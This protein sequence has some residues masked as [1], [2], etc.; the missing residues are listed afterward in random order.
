FQNR[1]PVPGSHFGVRPPGVLQWRF[2]RLSDGRL[3]ARRDALRQ[4]QPLLPG[5]LPGSPDTLQGS[6][7]ASIATGQEVLQTPVE[8]IMCWGT[9]FDLGEDVYDLGAVEMEPPAAPT[10]SCVDVAVLGFDCD[11]SMCRHRGV[12]NS[13]RNCHCSYG[14][15]P[16]LCTEPGFG[17]SIDSGPPPPYQ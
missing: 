16:P 17:G 10:R 2:L 13:N 3:Q 8:D 14:W 11:P 7:W 12:C 9:E 5:P 1:N 6:L 15:A 4:P